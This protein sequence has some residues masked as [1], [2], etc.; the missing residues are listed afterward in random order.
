MLHEDK[1]YYPEASEVYGAGVEAL[2]QDEDTQPLTEPIIQPIKVKKFSVTEKDAPETVYDKRYLVDLMDYPEVVRNVA[3][4]GQLHHGKTSLMDMLIL[5]CHN[6]T[7]D[8]SREMRYT[9]THPIARARE[10]SIKSMPM[11]L[12]LPTQQ[13]KSYLANIMDTPG[14][15]NFLDEVTAAL[16]IADG[17]VLVVD[18]LEGVMLQTEKILKQV[19]RENLPLTLVVNKV[20]RLILELKLPPADAYFK[21]KHTIDEVNTLL[22]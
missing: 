19:A 17:A 20:D 16:R 9:D 1:K 21:L 22:A 12:I 10:L 13:G 15:V 3:L 4:V 8:L 14:H 6:M 11:S 7:W 5:S 18:A 2:V